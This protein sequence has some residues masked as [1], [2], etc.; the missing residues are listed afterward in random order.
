MPLPNVNAASIHH[1]VN[2]CQSQW[3]IAEGEEL[4]NLCVASHYLD[5]PDLFDAACEKVALSLRG[6]SPCEIRSI[7]KM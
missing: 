4:L 2:W 1:V 5:I 6:R 7:L 3:L